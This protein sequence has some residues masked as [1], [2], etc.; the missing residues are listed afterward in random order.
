VPEGTRQ[1]TAGRAGTG[2]LWEALYTTRAIRYFTPEP[3]PDELVWQ[4]VDAGTMAPSGS[5]VQPWGF[6]VV[7]DDELRGRIATAV[8]ERFGANPMMR[9]LIDSAPTAERP[10]RLMYTGVGN[11]VEHFDEAPVL[12]VPVLDWSGTE[13]DQRPDGLPAGSS[14]FQA[15]QNILLAARGLGLGT[16]FTTF[17]REIHELPEWLGLPDGATPVALIPLGYP[18]RSFGPLN[19]KPVDTV[20]HW[21]RWGATR[22]R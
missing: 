19:R 9:D 10:K 15:T 13:P 2:D 6:V 12:I 5:N 3:V 18:D 16:V 17:Q 22:T 8:R 14:I 7:T 4:V 11:L 21:N 1:Y 20:T